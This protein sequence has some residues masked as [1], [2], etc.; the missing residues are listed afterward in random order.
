MKMEEVRCSHGNGDGHW[1]G[2]VVGIQSSRAA[3]FNNHPDLKGSTSTSICPENFMDSENMVKGIP[4]RNFHRIITIQPIIVRKDTP[5]DEIA[6][7]ILTNPR[8]RSFYVVDDRS[9]LVGKITLDRLVEQLFGE[10][11]LESEFDTFLAMKMSGKK[12]AGDIMIKPIYVTFDSVLKDAF[13]KM[14]HNKL[15]ELP[16]VDENLHIVGDLSMIEL[17]AA[18]VEKKEKAKGRDYLK[19]E[20]E[21]P[22]FNVTGY[23]S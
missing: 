6:K 22:F 23:K 10:M 8:T 15:Q 21:V 1:K 4:I 2:E 16:V 19:T 18:L 20:V 11:I 7:K 3:G 9:R 17:L 13:I 5:I 12:T 14:Y